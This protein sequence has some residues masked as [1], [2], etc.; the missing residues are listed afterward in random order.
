[1]HL[2]FVH[3]NSIGRG[4]R[5]VVNGPVV[6]WD[7]NLMTFYV[8]NIIDDGV[9]KPL[10][11]EEIT[12]YR[13]LF[14]LQLQMPNMWQNIISSDIRIVAIFAPIDDGNTRIYLRFYQK[15]MNVPGLKQ[16]VNGISSISNRYILHQDRR[17]VLTQL[18]KKTEL[19]MGEN[20]I[21]GDAPIIEF[22]KRRS[23]LRDSASRSESRNVDITT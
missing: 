23:A 21:Q 5:T 22:R 14:H 4:N 6:T 2:P 10:K 9:V 3:T 15:F 16:L 18:P 12:N 19:A 1:M 20:L 17:V 11:P 13:D 8:S 7:D